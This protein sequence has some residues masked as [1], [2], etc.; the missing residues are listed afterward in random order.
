MATQASAGPSMPIS[1]TG[2]LGSQW[3][4][5]SRA[6]TAVALLTAPAA[7]VWFRVHEDLALRYAL[8]LTLL[9]VA[10]FRGLV[11]VVFRRFIEWP[12]LFGTDSPELRAEDVVARRRSA[13]WRTMWKLAWRV[14]LLVTVSW[15]VLVFFGHGLSWSET[16]HGFLDA[17]SALTNGSILSQFIVLPFFFLFNF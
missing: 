3:R 14:F 5:L 16:A 1:P 7:F 11:D 2:E 6:A 17:L 12:S 8:L 9:E 13:F 4:S 15:L 10:A